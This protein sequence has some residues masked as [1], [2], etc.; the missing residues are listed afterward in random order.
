MICRSKTNYER[1]KGFSLPEVSVAVIILGLICSSVLVIIDRCVA[2]AAESAVRMRAFEVARENMETL[3]ASSSVKENVEYGQSEKYPD[4]GWQTVVETFY[5]PITARMWIRGVCSAQYTDSDDEEQTVELTHWL[6]DL[7]KEQLLQIEQRDE[8][9]LEELAGEL[10]ETLEDAADYAGVN[11]ETIEQ[12]LQNGLLT[13]E[14]GSF[15]KDN[16]DLYMRSSGNPSEE[17]KNQQ[18]KS[19][20]DLK[21]KRSQ[22]EDGS[23]GEAWKDEIDPKTGLTYGELEQM[24][25]SEVWELMQSRQQ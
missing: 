7:T 4:I 12:W 1:K 18:A 22:S 25:F 6:S 14:D 10:I 19:L 17:E 8:Q 21:N 24:D 2:S 9:E 23:T 13:T 11:V 15:I 20:A 5:E 16:L 3:L